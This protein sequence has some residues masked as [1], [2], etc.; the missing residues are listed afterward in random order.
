[1]K[2]SILHGRAFSTRQFLKEFLLVQPVLKC[3][4]TVDEHYWDFVGE[5]APE[6]V[7]GFYVHFAPVKAATTLQL[8]ELLFHDLAKMA[9]LAG[10][11]DHL[12]EQG[13]G[14]KSSKPNEVFP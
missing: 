7:V 3:L 11:Y 13:H 6:A 14:R 5:L 1:V 12:A 8:L 10:I 2:A 9:S 4:P